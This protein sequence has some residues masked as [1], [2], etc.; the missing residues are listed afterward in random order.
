MWVLQWR[1]PLYKRPQIVVHSQFRTGLKCTSAFTS[2]HLSLSIWTKIYHFG[3][4]ITNHKCYTTVLQNM[5]IDNWHTNGW[6][7]MSWLRVRQQIGK[8]TL[9]IPWPWTTLQ[10]ALVRK[11]PFGR[12]FISVLFPYTCHLKS[13]LEGSI[14]IF[15]QMP[16]FLCSYEWELWQQERACFLQKK[17]CWSLYQLN[18]ASKMVIIGFIH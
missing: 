2:V 8:E 6:R 7:S 15:K 4:K 9:S 12:F 3:P 11:T 14:I 13:Q 10:P 18:I 16:L 5:H 17:G 1:S